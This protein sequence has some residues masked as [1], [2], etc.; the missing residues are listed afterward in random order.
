MITIQFNA[1]SFLKNECK[2]KGIACP[3][4]NMQIDEGINLRQFIKTLGFKEDEIEG[5]F[6]NHKLV[7]FDTILKDRDRVALVPPGG[8][9]NHVRAYVGNA[10]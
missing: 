4:K 6:L 10:V 7:P 5:I 9:P 1:F 8:I 2:Q 3:N